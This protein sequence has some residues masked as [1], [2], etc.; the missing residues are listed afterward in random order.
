MGTD[1]LRRMRMIGDTIFLIGV[2]AFA[3]FRAG[4]ITRWSYTTAPR[5]HEVP[6]DAAHRTV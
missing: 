2:A 5:R 3:W 4:L 6:A 1:T